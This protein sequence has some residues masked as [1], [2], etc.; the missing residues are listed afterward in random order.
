MAARPGAMSTWAA[1]RPI[2]STTPIAVDGNTCFAIGNSATT[3]RDIY[4]T[5]DAGVTWQRHYAVSAWRFLVSHR[6][7]FADGWVYGVEWRDSP[8]HGWRARPGL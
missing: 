4:R 1:L 8:D 2:H 7:R 3:G 6:F 5:I